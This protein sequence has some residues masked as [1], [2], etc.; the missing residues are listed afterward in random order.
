MTVRRVVWAGV[1][2]LW[3]G[4]ACG[5]AG[6][7][8]TVLLKLR[9][10]DRITGTLLADEPGR[11]VL[12]SPVLGK[13]KVPRS[14]IENLTQQPEAVPALTPP[15]PN[16]ATK[17]DAAPAATADSGSPP[18]AAEATEPRAKRQRTK[19]KP[20]TDPGAP[21]APKRWQFDVQMGVNQQFNQAENELYHAN[22][23]ANW[24]NPTGRHRH[25]LAYTVNHGKT[26][27]TV[28][29]NNMLGSWRAEVDIGRRYFLFNA[30]SAGF[31]EIRRIDSGF[32]DGFGA[33]YVLLQRTNLTLRLDAGAN[34]L[35]QSFADG[36]EK[37]FFSPRLGE[38]G[39][40]KISKQVEFAQSLEFY[41]R[42]I[43][44]GNYRLRGE[45]VLRYLLGASM[46]FN[47]SV[48]DIYDTEPAAGVTP[49]DLQV[50][51]SLGVRF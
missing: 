7:A 50:R 31:D 48:I 12:R 44:F 36:T 38:N 30:A 34:Y 6:A 18:A 9:N 11:V 40:W 29:V 33:G 17:P 35:K 19:T 3:I 46:T 1:G 22:L 41:P 25:Q 28:T 32:E 49:N 13:V 8:D 2:M 47:L 42:S 10:G 24:A 4:A 20:P 26:E 45:A 21:K 14:E 43:D 5:A 51:S 37:D 23:R 27:D 39:L 16:A 15:S